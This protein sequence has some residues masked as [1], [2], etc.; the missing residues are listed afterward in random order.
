VWA[1]RLELLP[2]ILAS[3]SRADETTICAWIA[4]AVQSLSDEWKAN[5]GAARPHTYRTRSPRSTL[6][7]GQRSG[8]RTR[9]RGPG[10]QRVLVVLVPATSWSP[11]HLAKRRSRL[12]GGH[13]RKAAIAKPAFLVIAPA[14]SRATTFS[15]TRPATRYAPRTKTALALDTPARPIR[16]PREPRTGA[17]PQRLRRRSTRWR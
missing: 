9:P 2:P 15:P 14:I 12:E 5:R 3:N 1:D 6:R 17:R 4:L 16:P 8:G 7:R 11:R 13:G 10:S